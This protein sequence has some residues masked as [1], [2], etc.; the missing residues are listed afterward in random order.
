M[1]SL[2]VLTVSTLCTADEYR[3]NLDSASGRPAYINATFVDVSGNSVCILHIV[4][5]N[6]GFQGY[7]RHNMYITTQGPVANTIPDFWCMVWEQDSDVIV[8]LT[9][10]H[11][12]GTVRF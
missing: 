4:G 8:M 10:L 2:V 1:Y 5:S 9:E 12:D 11:E 7:P 6:L 3:V